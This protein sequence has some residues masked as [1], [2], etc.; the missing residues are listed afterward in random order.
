M[1]GANDPKLLELRPAIEQYLAFMQQAGYAASAI[2]KRRRHL[3]SLE[4]FVQGRGMKSLDEFQPEDAAGFVQHWL[5]SHP[6]AKRRRNLWYRGRFRPGHHLDLQCS[7]RAFLRWAKPAGLMQGE[8]FPLVKPAAA[9]WLP[10][11][12]RAYLAFC[13]QHK[14]LAPSTLRPIER[15]LRRLARFL[16]RRRIQDWDRM[17]FA[18]IDGFVRCETALHERNVQHVNSILRGLFRHLHSQGLLQRDWASAL[19]SPRRHRLARTPRPLAPDQVLALL[20]GAGRSRP[21]GR[22]DFAV[23]LLA[24]SLGLRAS[25]IASLTLEDVDWRRQLL[26]VPRA[27]GGTEPT[28]P[29]SAALI[30]ALADYLKHERLPGSPH[31]NLFLRQTAPRGPLCPGSVSTIFRVR[32]RRAGIAGS[33]HQLRH[34]FASQ[35]LRTGVGYPTLQKLMGHRSPSSTQAYTK[36]DLD[37][38]AQAAENDAQ[39]Y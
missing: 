24:A 22:R 10:P 15:V 32:M 5:D 25:E 29:L 34:A 14:G 7:M 20:E 8:P 28:L 38:L 31:R 19:L 12:V 21:G 26:R 27:K 16:Q 37:Q 9:R 30:Q 6:G 35:M 2:A 18:H 33:G 3:L 39:D 17:T 23:L 1:R 4:R 11:Q 36:I 13:R